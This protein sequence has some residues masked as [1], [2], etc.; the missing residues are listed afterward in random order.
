MTTNHYASAIHL[1]GR[2]R[3]LAQPTQDQALWALS[4]GLEQLAKAIQQ[5]MDEF[6]GSLYELSQRVK[7]LK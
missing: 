7:H 4:N 3:E 2:A 1:L 5:D 6:R